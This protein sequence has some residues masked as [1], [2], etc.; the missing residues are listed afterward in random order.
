MVYNWTNIVQQLTYPSTCVL[1]GAPGEE[2]RDLCPGCHRDLPHNHHPCP[3][4][5]QPLPESASP[6]MP[7]GECQKSPPR[8]DSCLAAFRYESPLDHLIGNLKFHGRLSHGR[9]LAELLGRYLQQRQEQLPQLII[10]VP[11][12]PS[13]LRERGFNQALELAQPIGRLLNIPVASTLCIRNRATAPQLG[14]DRKARR[15]NVRGAFEL[16]GEL[17]AEHV[18]LVDDVVTTGN[19]VNELAIQ[20]R[21]HGA[22]QI[23]VWAVARRAGPRP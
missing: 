19:T 22:K 8:F 5:A 6:D 12:H 23:E 18:V 2:D 7:C 15:R 3:R 13:R 1:C 10:P 11:L 9:L 14:L 4:C 16:R 17:T 21:R 20:L